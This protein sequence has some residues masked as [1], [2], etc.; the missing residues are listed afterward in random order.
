MFGLQSLPSPDDYERLKEKRQKQLLREIEAQ[1]QAE[2]EA[3]RLAAKM[4]EVRLLLIRNNERN[5]FGAL[6]YGE[7][8][9][10]YLGEERM[11]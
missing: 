2:L 6:G 7:L 5:L 9:T 3:K 8:A 4:E 11:N 10:G 1:R